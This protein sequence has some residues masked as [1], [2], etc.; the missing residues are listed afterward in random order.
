L[1]EVSH[2]AEG[3]HIFMG[4]EDG[5]PVACCPL[6]AREPGCFE[7]S[8]M[9]VHEA[10]RGAGIGLKLVEHAIERAKALGAKRLYLE[11]SVKLPNAVHVYEKAGF[12]HLPPERVAPSPYARSSVY[13]EMAI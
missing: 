6:I 3:R 10:R 13:M 12:R 5:G 9:A 8:R 2:F 11:S 7:L 1:N 4:E